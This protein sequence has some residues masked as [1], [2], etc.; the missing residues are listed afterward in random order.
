MRTLLSDPLPQEVQELLTRRRQWG[1]DRHDEVWEGVLH[2]VPMP[3]FR[4]AALSAQVASLLRAPASAAGLTVTDAFN[5]GD[6]KQNFRVPDAG[7]HRPDAGGLWLPSAALAVEV[8]SPNDDTW[9]KLSFYAAH[10][11]DELLIVD[12]ERRSLDWLGL[13]EGRYQP[14]E[15]SGVIDLSAA[16]LARQIEWV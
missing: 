4:H 7:L 15:H 1:A 2:V 6:S 8:L 12:P 3:D 11:V 13:V 10:S 9:K 5:L 14:I 16:A